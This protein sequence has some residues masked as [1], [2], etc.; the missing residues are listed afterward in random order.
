MSGAWS[1]SGITPAFGGYVINTM[2]TIGGVSNVSFVGS[3]YTG[4]S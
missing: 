2:V 3:L 4:G 1:G